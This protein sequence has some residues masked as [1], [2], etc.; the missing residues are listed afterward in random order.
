MTDDGSYG[1]KGVVT[2][3]VEEVIKREHV[4]K[5]LAIGPPVMMKFTS[6]LAHKYGI[7]NDVSLNT[8]M[9][10]GTG[11][12]GACRLTIGGKTKFVCIDGPEFDGDLVDWDEMMKRMGTFKGVEK[13]EM[14][15][16]E[17]HLHHGGETK[18]CGACNTAETVATSPNDG[19]E[20]VESL[21][22]R[23]A[24]WREELRKR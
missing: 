11:M 7:P 23:N 13:E 16:Y 21:V 3:G 22:D 1:E 8:I 14:E 24:P 17:Q 15:H 6:L 2:V 5:V 10:D 9:V 20:P 4:D 12:C 19:K 18:T